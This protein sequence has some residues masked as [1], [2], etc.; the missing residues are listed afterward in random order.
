MKK[1]LVLFALFTSFV[2]AETKSFE[3]GLVSPVQLGSPKDDVDGFRLSLLYTENR[4]VSGFDVTFLAS[5]TSGT[6]NGFKLGGIYDSIEKGGKVYQFGG[7]ITDI[8]GSVKIGQVGVGFSLV[9]KAEGFRAFNFV[10]YADSMKGVDFG[11][12]NYANKID[13][14]QIG[15]F[16]YA[17][18]L[19]GYQIGL[20]NYAKNSSIFPVL[21]FFNKGK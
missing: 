8:N 10:N 18:N 14:L 11:T 4:N 2:F 20:I 3:L 15:F 5:K 6:F 16:N 17:N 19:K 12:I 1:L 9:E 13:G 21:P 7:F